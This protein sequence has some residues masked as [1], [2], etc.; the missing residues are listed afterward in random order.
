MAPGHNS[1]V[2]QTPTRHLSS[3]QIPLAYTCM[4]QRCVQQFPG[5]SMGWDGCNDNKHRV[6]FACPLSAWS[7]WD[8]AFK[9]GD[10]LEL[11]SHSLRG[12]C[13]VQGN[14]GAMHQSWVHPTDLELST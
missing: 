12:L 11:L 14:Q 7:T 6:S 2:Q 8:D 13:E 5:D 9:E 4:L 3:Q 10:L 1:N